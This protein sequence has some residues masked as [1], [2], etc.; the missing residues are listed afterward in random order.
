MSEHSEPGPGSA[1]FVERL[2]R[3]LKLDATLYEEVEHDPSAMGQ[4]VG[5]VSL[6]AL[7]AAL[8]TPASGFVE[9]L[10][11]AFLG[12]ALGAG[13]IWLV[14][15]RIMDCTSDYGELLRTTGFAQAPGMAMALGVFPAV[16][17]VVAPVV[18]IWGLAAYV[19]GVRQALDVSTGRAVW[20]CVLAVVLRLALGAL[21]VWV[22]GG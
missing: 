19:I 16:G 17:L 18:V 22:F 11:G 6:A 13:L 15:V 10:L 3:A 14:G 2:L 4:A 21:L 5:V 12:W 20:I 8:G 7:A 9:G 1:S